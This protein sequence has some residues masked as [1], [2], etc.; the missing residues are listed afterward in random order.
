M[1]EW[2]AFLILFLTFSHIKLKKTRQSGDIVL[3]RRCFKIIFI[4]E[5]VGMTGFEPATPRTPCVCATRLRHIPWF[6][7]QKVDLVGVAGLSSQLP[8]RFHRDAMTGHQYPNVIY[9]SRGGRIRTCD[10]LLPKQA[11]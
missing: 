3:M 4:R 1:A 10:L 6:R 5:K 9:F 11:R 7:N 8:S 2:I